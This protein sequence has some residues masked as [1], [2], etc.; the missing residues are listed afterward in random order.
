MIYRQYII[1]IPTKLY[2]I[3]QMIFLND[4]LQLSGICFSPLFFSPQLHFPL[5]ELLRNFGERLK[6][7]MLP[8]LFRIQAGHIYNNRQSLRCFANIILWYNIGNPFHRQCRKCRLKY[9]DIMRHQRLKHIT[10][11]YCFLFYGG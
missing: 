10:I 2:L 4:A 7:K 6:K 3:F 8:L 5:R 1:R 11:F 9:S